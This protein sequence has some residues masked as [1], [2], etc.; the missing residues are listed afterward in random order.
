MADDGGGGTDEAERGYAAL[1]WAESRLAAPVGGGGAGGG[2]VVDPERAEACIAELTRIANELR[3]Q[4][5]S[6]GSLRFDPPGSDEVSLNMA[7]NGFEMSQ[8]AVNFVR[9]WAGQIELT[10]DALQRQLDGYRG[11]EDANAQAL[12]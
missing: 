9:T 11:I 8:R 3:I 5:M 10:R 7:D 6:A 1:T 2:F 4:A 12:A